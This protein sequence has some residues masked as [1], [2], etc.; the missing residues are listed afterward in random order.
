MPEL[1][2][3]VLDQLFL[4]AR[5]HNGWLDRPV[6][7]ETIHRLYDVMRMGPTSANTTPVRIV[8][9]KSREAKERLKPAL[10]A[11][12][13]D[14]TMAAPVTAIVAYDPNFYEHLPRLFPGRDMKSMFASMPEAARN[15]AAV[16]NA[17]LQGGYLIIA[18]RALGLDCGPM[19]GFDR[20]KVDAA[21]LAELSWKSLFLLNLGYGDATQVFPRNPRFDFAEA[22]RIE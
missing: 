7:D 3:S 20:A 8:F 13:V 2:T 19:A 6:S 17:A 10:M 5:T 4:K 16:L 18:A 12:N 11:S 1:D 9:V 22:A 14:K 15:H 21:F